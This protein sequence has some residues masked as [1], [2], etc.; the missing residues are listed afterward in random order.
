[1]GIP[2]AGKSR[3]AEGLVTAATS[4]STATSAAGR[5]ATSPR[6]ST[7]SS[8]RRRDADR[9]RQH[10]PHACVAELRRRGGGPAR[11]SG[12]LHLDRHAARPG[13][14]Q[15]RRAAARPLRLA[16]DSR[17]AER[18]CPP[19][20]GS[21]CAGVADAR[22]P[23]AGAAVDR[24][25]I[26]RVEQVPFVRGAR[27]RTRAG[28]FVAAAA[29]EAARL[30]GRARRR[31][32]PRAS[33]RVRLEPGR[34]ASMGSTRSSASL[35]ARVAGPVETALCA[36]PA[37]PP[38]CWCRPPLPGLPLAFARAH[39]VDPAR[40]IL[41]GAARHTGRSPRRSAPDSPQ[42]DLRAT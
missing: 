29:L 10:V 1:M 24:R 11:H 31:R 41:V 16:S 6:R 39:G 30:G 25:G 7:T 32:S 5:C 20:A 34:H 28:V 9:P 37:G 22:A 17:G 35:A 4:V 23:R 36:H 21:S 33:P 38:I 14:G 18:A 12:A 13:A 27:P 15:S 2:G 42:S 40:S 8:R 3:V 26:C 19:R